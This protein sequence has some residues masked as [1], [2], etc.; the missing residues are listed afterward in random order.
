[1]H[2]HFCPQGNERQANQDYPPSSNAIR[3]RV[4]CVK[5]MV[6]QPAEFRFRCCCT[7]GRHAASFLISA[8]TWSYS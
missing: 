1:M 6:G 7:T 3:L 8:T 5:H 4:P 2:Q